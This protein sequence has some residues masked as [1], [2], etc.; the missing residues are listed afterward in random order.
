MELSVKETE[1]LRPLFKGLGLP[2]TELALKAVLGTIKDG[3]VPRRYANET[4]FSPYNAGVLVPILHARGEQYT[5]VVGQIF[6]QMDE[7]LRTHFPDV[8][9]RSLNEW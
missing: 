5:S 1:S 9:G 7:R 3:V 2:D 4:R 6:A 8:D